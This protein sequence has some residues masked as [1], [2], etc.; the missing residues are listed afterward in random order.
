MS[1]TTQWMTIGEIAKR[2]GIGVETVR[3]YQ[4]RGLIVEPPRPVRGF[5]RYSYDTLRL[6]QF[7]RRAKGLGFSL[8]EIA[9]LVSMR[10]NRRGAHSDLLRVMS[11]K[12][13]EIAGK[14]RELEVK[15]RAL[16]RLSEACRPLGSADRWRVFE[17]NGHEN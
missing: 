15:R 1:S 17:A 8:K 12:E 11:T 5:R 2:A 14:I 4:R 3:Y 10:Q 9:T 6:L 16:R 13:Q 7:I